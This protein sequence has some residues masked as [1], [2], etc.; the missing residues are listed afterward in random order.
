MCQGCVRGLSCSWSPV[1][2][3]RLNLGEE[4]G[5]RRERERRGGRGGEWGE[6]GEE[7]VNSTILNLL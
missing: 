6:G 7:A 3:K 5:G 1:S 2:F 4:G